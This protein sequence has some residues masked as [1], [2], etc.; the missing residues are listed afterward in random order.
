MREWLKDL[1]VSKGLS[2]K[3]VAKRVGVTQ[4]YYNFI[5]LGKR[6]SLEKNRVEQKIAE[7]LDF[8]WTR[9]YEDE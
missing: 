4:Q 8:E 5:E 1:R 3:E 7:I 6:G 2:Q 9:F